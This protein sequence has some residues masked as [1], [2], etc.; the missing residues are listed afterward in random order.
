MMQTIAEFVRARATDDSALLHGDSRWL[1]RRVRA[2]CARSAPP[3]RSPTAA[4]ARS[5]LGIL[6]D[7][8]PEFPFWIGARAAGRCDDGRTSTPRAAAPTSNATS[9]TATASS[10]SPTMPGCT[11]STACA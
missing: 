4:R 7:N 2:R 11:R 10:S 6:L 5:T 9:T 3:G 1:L 8:V